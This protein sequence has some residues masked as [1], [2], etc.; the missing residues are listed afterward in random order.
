MCLLRLCVCVLICGLHRQ[1]VH[2][3]ARDLDYVLKQPGGT[4]YRID[5]IRGF[6][7]FPQTHHVESVAV[8]TWVGAA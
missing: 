5:S 2:S 6:D 1:N 7:F 3:Q 4:G 8:L